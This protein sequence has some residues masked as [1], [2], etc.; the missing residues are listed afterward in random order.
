MVLLAA[1]GGERQGRAA[2]R[3]AR[4]AP[5]DPQ[6]ATAG[7]CVGARGGSA[8]SLRSDAVSGIDCS[9]GSA[10]DLRGPSGRVDHARRLGPPAAAIDAARQ[11][12][13][14]EKAGLRVTTLTSGGV[15]P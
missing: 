2:R 4:P 8:R 14:N 3:A 15:S 5:Q 9:I 10:D 7:D 6:P 11:R 13:D 12:G 1:A